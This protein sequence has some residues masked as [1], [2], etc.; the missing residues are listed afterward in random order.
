MKILASVLALAITA[1]SAPAFACG[2]MIKLTTAK[3]TKKAKRAER[4]VGQWPALV[5]RDGKLFLELHYP[6]FDLSDERR[7]MD[8]FELV[9]NDQ[10]A[11]LRHHLEW[12]G[13]SST[14]VTIQQTKG[15]AWK[16]V[17]FAEEQA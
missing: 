12:H 13:K 6:V 1:T 15:G 7:Y 9:D 8:Y 11:Q 3:K 14:L 17:S 10:A 16:V 2:D 5:E 4:A